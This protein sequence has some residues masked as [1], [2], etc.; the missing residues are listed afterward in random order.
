MRKKISL[1]ALLLAF[2]L[3]GS[4]FAQTGPNKINSAIDLLGGA[5]QQNGLPAGWT[6]AADNYECTVKFTESGAIYFERR[7]KDEKCSFAF[8][9]EVPEGEYVLQTDFT[10]DGNGSEIFLD[11]APLEKK[12]KL[13]TAGGKIR[14]G[15]Q[16]K[17]IGKVWGWINKMT[18]ARTGGLT[19]SAKVKEKSPSKAKG[20]S[21]QAIAKITQIAAGCSC[22]SYEW[23]NRGRAPIGYIKG[24]A[25]TYAESY[26]EL[27]MQP[28]NAVRIMSGNISETSKDALAY[29]NLKAGTEVERLRSVFTLALGLGMRESSGN[30]TEGRDESVPAKKATEDNAEAGLFQVSYDSF[31]VSSEFPALFAKYKSNAER[32]RLSVFMEGAKDRK[33]PLVGGGKGAEF[34]KFTKQCPAFASEYVAIMLRLNRRHFGPINRKEAEYLESAEKMFEQI[35]SIV[36]A[37]V[38][39]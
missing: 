20:L 17:G 24:A 12:H 6:T 34:Q 3:S 36:D 23:K 22:V 10:I 27:R 8:T 38:N 31:G 19:N 13:V 1:T 5:V 30:V 9:A 28:T 4:I 14:V 32:C 7:L 21:N 37:E 25:L 18:A 29:Y 35:E 2:I 11:G 39:S 16:T 15:I 33:K 26:F